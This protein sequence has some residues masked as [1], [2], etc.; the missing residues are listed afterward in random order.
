MNIKNDVKALSRN[1]AKLGLQQ[2][3]AESSLA[4]ESFRVVYVNKQLQQGAQAPGKR[5]K[6]DAS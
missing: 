4:D 5:K 6:K 3:L 1:L 2:V